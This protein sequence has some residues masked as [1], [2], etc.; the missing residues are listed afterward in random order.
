MTAALILALAVVSTLAAGASVTDRGWRRHLTGAG[1]LL[2]VTLLA[3]PVAA[4]GLGRGLALGEAGVGLVLVAAAPG[5]STGPLLAL[6]GRGD[7]GVAAALFA[8]LA[9]VGTAAALVATALLDVADGAAVLR[10]AAAVVAVSFGPLVAGLALAARRPAAAARLGR[11]LSAAG[12]ALL[13]ATVVALA[14]DYGHHLAGPPT[15]AAAAALLVVAA[16]PALGLAGTAR[17]VAAVQV[18]LVRN[19]TLALVVA[20]AIEAPPPAVGAVLSF[21]LVMYAVA[22]GLALAARL[23][24]GSPRSW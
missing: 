5:G 17:R 1:P 22:A 14:I 23:R 21:G 19:L 12:A 15:L 7:P 3:L 18:T 11:R 24:V 13:V 20:V 10:A 16:A 2:V 6:L 4:W 8:V 9:A